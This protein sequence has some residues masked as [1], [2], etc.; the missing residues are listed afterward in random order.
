MFSPGVDIANACQY[1]LLSGSDIMALVADVA[2]S[3]TLYWSNVI[4]WSFPPGA[5]D[6]GIQCRCYPI[7]PEQW[8]CRCPGYTYQVFIANLIADPS[9]YNAVL[10]IVVMVFGGSSAQ[11]A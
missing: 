9:G 10:E 3:L 6:S 7:Y 5:F 1:A 2:P 8:W 4:G 11:H